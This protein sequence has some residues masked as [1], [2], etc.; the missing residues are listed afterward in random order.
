MNAPFFRALEHAFQQ[1]PVV[2]EIIGD[3]PHVGVGLQV[4]RLF[5][6]RGAGGKA[7]DD[8]PSAVPA[9]FGDQFDFP[10]AAR[11]FPDNIVALDEVDAPGGVQAENTVVIGFRVRCV[12][13]QAVHVR[14]P[15]TDGMRIGRQMAGAVAVRD[16]QA[17]VRRGAGKAAHNMDAELQPQRMHII[18]QGAETGPILCGREA[19][20]RRRQPAVSVH[21]QFGERLIRM[22]PGVGTG[23]LDVHNDVFPAKRLQEARH[24]LRVPADV[25]LGYGGAVAVPAV[26]AHGRRLSSHVRFLLCR[27]QPIHYI[28]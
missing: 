5:Q 1:P 24:V 6:R 3:T 18:R 10:P 13:A 21:L 11:V 9:A 28:R 17:P 4:L 27:H 14:I 20:E 12:A 16:R 8:F 26:P 2:P 19:V 22:V 23:P 25:R 7:Q 15:V